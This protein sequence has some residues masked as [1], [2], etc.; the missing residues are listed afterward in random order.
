MYGFQVHAGAFLCA[1][2]IF[3]EEN[4]SYLNGEPIAHVTISKRRSGRTA[5]VCIMCHLPNF[6]QMGL[7][8]VQNVIRVHCV[9]M[10]YVSFAKMGLK[11][12]QNVMRAHCV[13]IG[14]VCYDPKKQG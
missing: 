14:Y 4:E 8:V 10:H 6:A 5:Y 1:L 11:V 9:C 12:V 7:K 3:G 2:G 13:C